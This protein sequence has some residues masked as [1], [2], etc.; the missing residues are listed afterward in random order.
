MK[1]LKR[2]IIILAILVITIGMGTFAL[3][4]YNLD[5]IYVKNKSIDSTLQGTKVEGITNILLVGIDGKNVEKG[6]RSD[7]VR[8]E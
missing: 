2:V 7:S 3:V 8:V 5:K 4:Y 6:N 1:I